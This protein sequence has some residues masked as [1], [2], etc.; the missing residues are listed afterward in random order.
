MNLCVLG[1]IVQQTP[2]GVTIKHVVEARCIHD[3][4][5]LLP[6]SR[7]LS[8]ALFLH[9]VNTVAEAPRLSRR[10]AERDAGFYLCCAPCQILDGC[11]PF[12]RHSHSCSQLFPGKH[13]SI[14]N[15]VDAYLNHERLCK[16]DTC[17]IV[18]PL[19]IRIDCEIRV[20]ARG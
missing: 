16:Y 13:Y 5:L 7:S 3:K 6:V 19:L 8:L 15:N 11:T 9:P 1:W 20:C 2:T 4:L 17:I 10:T 12:V 14:P 18:L